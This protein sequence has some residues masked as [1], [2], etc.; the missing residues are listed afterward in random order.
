MKSPEALNDL[1]EIN[2][3]RVEGYEKAAAQADDVD[4]KSIFHSNA[5]ES[6]KF[7]D[8]LK[9]LVIKQGGEPAKDTTLRGK[10]YRTWMDVKATFG[11][12]NRKAVLSSCEFGEDA[13]QRAYNS[14]LEDKDLPAE[15]RSVVERQKAVLRGAHDRIKAMRDSEPTK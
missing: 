9:E 6:K 10:I 4:L 5:A 15:A 3:D 13:A 14:A 1:I 7:A 12:D 11:G 2:K 8:E